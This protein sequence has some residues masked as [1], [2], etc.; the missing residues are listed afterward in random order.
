M[1]SIGT[2]SLQGIINLS[3]NVDYTDAFSINSLHILENTLMLMKARRK[4]T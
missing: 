1:S 4:L 2:N 3:R